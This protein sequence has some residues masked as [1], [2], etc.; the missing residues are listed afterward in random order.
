MRDGSSGSRMRVGRSASGGLGAEGGAGAAVGAGGAGGA[1]S[2]TAPRR[3]AAH[4][5][6]SPALDL[7]VF[8]VPGLNLKVPPLPR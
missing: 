6:P 1:A 7:T 3:K 2:P 8:R 4:A 5:R